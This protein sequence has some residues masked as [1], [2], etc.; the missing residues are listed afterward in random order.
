[1]ESKSIPEWERKELR[2]EVKWLAV[3]GQQLEWSGMSGLFSFFF[4]A[5]HQLLSGGEEL[6]LSTAKRSRCLSF[7]SFWKSCGTLSTD[8]R[9]YLLCA[10]ICSHVMEQHAVKSFV[11]LEKVVKIIA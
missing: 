5:E 11:S 10:S 2:V 6:I 3:R 8:L 4:A 9:A 7:G 1:M